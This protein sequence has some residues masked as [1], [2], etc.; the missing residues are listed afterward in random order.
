MQLISFKVDLLTRGEVLMLEYS[1]DAAA[2]SRERRSGIPQ[3]MSESL[4]T[5][6][7]NDLDQNDQELRGVNSR[8]SSVEKKISFLQGEVSGLTKAAKAGASGRK[9]KYATMKKLRLIGI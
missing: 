2:Q 3:T 5:Q 6:L 9:N 8:I 1:E 7:R 4:R